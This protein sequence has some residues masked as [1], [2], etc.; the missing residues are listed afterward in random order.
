MQECIS[1][2]LSSVCFDSVITSWSFANKICI[3]RTSLEKETEVSPLCVCG[4]IKGKH[5]KCGTFCSLQG[6]LKVPP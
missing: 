1:L 6:E 3:A 2:Y 5:A 4:I